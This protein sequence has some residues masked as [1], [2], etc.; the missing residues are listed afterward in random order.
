MRLDGA[1]LSLS[2]FSRKAAKQVVWIAVALWTGFTFVGYFTPIKELAGLFANW[3][4]GPWETFWVF[5]Y[6]FATYGNA[7]FMREQ[8]CKYMCP[9]ARFQSA[10]FDKDTLIV[11]YDTVRGEPR[12]ATVQEG[13]SGGT[14]IGRVRGLHPVCPGVPDRDRYSQGPSV[15]VHQLRRV[16]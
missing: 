10:M 2:K 11:S 3:G 14:W 16:H 5:F 6:G 12:G 4:M 13:G 15:R 9:Y 7:G 8:V 1:P